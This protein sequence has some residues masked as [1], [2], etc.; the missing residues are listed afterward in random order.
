[1]SEEEKA[2]WHCYWPLSPPPEDR[3]SVKLL[4]SAPMSVS[5]GVVAQV[6]LMGREKTVDAI[7]LAVP[8]SFMKLEEFQRLG[9][10]V[11]SEMF[12][13]LSILYSGTV[14]FISLGNDQR[15]SIG[16]FSDDELPTGIPAHIE[17]PSP[18][19]PNWDLKSVY[20]LFLGAEQHADAV[21][22]LSEALRD[23]I[24]RHYRFLS[25]CRALEL[26]EKDAPARRAW[27]EQYEPRFR[28]LDVDLRHLKNYLPDLRSR[29][30][31]GV[32]TGGHHG[33]TGVN[34][35]GVA[36]EVFGLMLDIVLDKLGERTG[37]KLGRSPMS[38]AEDSN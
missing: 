21:A 10:R 9:G 25:L 2:F 20:N 19:P 16:Y 37:M 23:E 7:L 6:C 15:F 1:M 30:S 29:C 27:I 35:G 38:G 36:D 33:I 17:L 4:A 32:G 24:P 14:R 5:D 11:Q 31:H 18:P 13:A 3:A 26:L 12:A 34:S 28:E 8:S 22:A